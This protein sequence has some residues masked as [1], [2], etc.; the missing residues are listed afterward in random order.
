ME[1]HQKVAKSCIQDMKYD[2][3]GV[4]RGSEMGERLGKNSIIAFVSEL[5]TKHENILDISDHSNAED[6]CKNN[7]NSTKPK[8]STKYSHLVFGIT[9][10]VLASPSSSSF[11]LSLLFPLLLLLPSR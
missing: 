1:C 11:S 8:I 2:I 4:N 6:I 3:I 9:L 10:F 5:K 7:N